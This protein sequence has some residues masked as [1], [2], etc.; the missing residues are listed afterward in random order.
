MS[1]TTAL[2]IA[3]VARALAQQRGPT[4]EDRRIQEGITKTMRAVVAEQTD[5]SP[6]RIKNPNGAGDPAAP[7][8]QAEGAAWALRQ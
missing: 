6:S 2:G 8:G 1:E 4:A 7:D 5:T 3:A